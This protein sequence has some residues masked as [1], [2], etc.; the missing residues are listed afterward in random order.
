[1]RPILREPAITIVTSAF[2]IHSH[3]ND[4]GRGDAGYIG[5]QS[6][7]EDTC[8]RATSVYRWALL[9][10]NSCLCCTCLQLLFAVS[11][12]DEP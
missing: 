12:A 5:G 4:A 11:R 6:P 10:A 2:S 1:M 8:N 3:R 9:Q 7:G